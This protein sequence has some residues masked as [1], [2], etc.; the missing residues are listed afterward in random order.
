[1]SRDRIVLETVE[2]TLSLYAQRHRVPE[3]TQRD[4]TIKQAQ[5]KEKEAKATLENANRGQP[6]RRYLVQAAIDWGVII[7][8]LVRREQLHARLDRVPA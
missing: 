7:S 3:L 5:E 6:G 2:N 8:L 4:F 1:M